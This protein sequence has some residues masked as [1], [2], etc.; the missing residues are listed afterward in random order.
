MLSANSRRNVG[1][2]L[3]LHQRAWALQRG[4]ATITWTFDPLVRRNA[5]FNL[6]KLGV[7]A[8]RYLPNF[9]G[10]MQDP[11]N[12]GDDTDR[13]LVDWD[14]ASPPKRPDR[15]HALARPPSA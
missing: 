10:A 15:G 12:A 2:A 8:T 14:L 7:R 3:K 4:I 5:Y 11:I 13:L 6:A 1:Y 9:Y